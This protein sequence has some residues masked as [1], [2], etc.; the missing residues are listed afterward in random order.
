LKKVKILEGGRAMLALE[1]IE[2]TALNQCH[3]CGAEQLMLDKFCRRCGTR[4]FNSYNTSSDLAH[5]RACETKPLQSGEQR[6]QSFS[7]QLI[8]VVAQTMSART[9]TRNHSR[10]LQRLICT[11][12]TIPIWMLIVMLSPLDA[13]AAA[14]AAAGCTG[15][16]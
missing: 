15:S 4:R 2:T 8:H 1:E 9:G 11:L 6:C 12:I 7:G 13:I 16:Q 5:A 14:R 3:G 10:G